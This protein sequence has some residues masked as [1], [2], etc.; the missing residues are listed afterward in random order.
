M[1]NSNLYPDIEFNNNVYSVTTKAPIIQI[2]KICKSNCLLVIGEGSIG[3]STAMTVLQATLLHE[4]DIPCFLFECKYMNTQNVNEIQAP[5]RNSVVII[6]G[7][8]EVKNNI[9]DK[10]I[11]KIQSLIEQNIKIVV[12]S[13]YN[14][15]NYDGNE[16]EVFSDFEVAQVLTFSDERL[17]DIVG[18]KVLEN[19]NYAQLLKN[20]MFLKLHIEFTQKG[21]ADEYSNE[22]NSETDFLEKYFGLLYQKKEYSDDLT[23]Y[24]TDLHAVGDK[25]YNRFFDNI[26]DDEK[27]EIPKELSHIFYYKDGI[28]YSTHLK[29]E[30][31]ALA[32]Y[33]KRNLTSYFSRWGNKKTFFKYFIEQLLG[34]DVSVYKTNIERDVAEAFYYLG[35]MLQKSPF[36]SAI[37]GAMDQKSFKKP[38][39]LFANILCAYIGYNESTLD[40]N[41]CNVDETFDEILSE[42]YRRGMTYFCKFIRHLRTR[43]ILNIYPLLCQLPHLQE[44]KIHNDTYTSINNCLISKK[45]RSLVLACINSVIPNDVSV[46]KIGY[47]AFSRIADLKKIVIPAGIEQVDDCAIFQCERLEHI[48]FGPDVTYISATAVIGCNKLSKLTVAN[49]NRFFYAINNCIVDTEKKAMILGCATSVIPSDGS[50]IEICEDVY[51][52]TEELTSLVVPD[53][54]KI[55]RTEAIVNC[56]NLESI[57]IGRDVHCIE[58]A[59]IYACHQLR[60]IVV[61]K[62]NPHYRSINNCLIETHSGKVLLVANKARIPAIDD[63]KSIASMAFGCWKNDILTYDEFSI[64]SNI[65]LIEPSAFT[66][67]HGPYSIDS[68][69]KHCH[70]GVVYV[71]N[72]DNPYLVAVSSFS[73]YNKI[74]I[75]EDTRIVYQLSGNYEEI[76]ITDNVHSISA[77][78]LIRATCKRLRIGKN[79]RHIEAP[80]YIF[81]NKNIDFT[82]SEE[83]PNY[84]VCCGT[85]MEKESGRLVLG[86]ENGYIPD[87]ATVIGK[88]AFAHMG[89][90]SLT[91]PDQITK[92]EQAAFEHCSALVD[93]SISPN[94]KEI[95]DE[96]FLGCSSLE[97]LIIPEGVTTIGASAFIECNG[98]KYV[99]IPDSVTNIKLDQYGRNPFGSDC[100]IEKISLPKH[101]I[102]L[103][104][105]LNCDCEVI[106]RD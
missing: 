23:K 100:E 31:F 41:A 40:D 68:N 28:L 54:V 96:A 101:L 17:R 11:S 57:Y 18:E 86:N 75:H 10:L 71:G 91:M 29:Y 104:E 83:N 3:K 106:V 98:L 6:D 49:D 65:M 102:W 24:R 19:H 50:V 97:N 35:Q 43:Y 105:L 72:E 38:S 15:K 30:H 45:D 55:I 103:D 64:P 37:I 1:I 39:Y 22:I 58:P 48:E 76:T 44:I 56:D 62:S 67:V 82:I 20:T 46:K 84:Y 81:S 33:M 92:I 27:M 69:A 32:I 78:V 87:T 2:F 79:V 61:H 74:R 80:L 42:L 89:I 8:D 52:D 73:D 59:A 99:Y 14:P 85:I 7:W 77:G 90:Q 25:L 88:Y 94:V 21:V 70:N 93:I 9:R 66:V 53:G 12:T 63:V 36:G 13:R 5:C 95:P 47:H 51:T 4:E 26:I 16:K 34:V 60:K